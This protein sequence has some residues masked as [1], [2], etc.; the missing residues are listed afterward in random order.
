MEATNEGETG[1]NARGKPSKKTGDTAEH[2]K[3][4]DNSRQLRITISHGDLQ[5]AAYPVIAGH[6]ENDG[7]LNAE[8]AI[9]GNLDQALM[10]RHQLGIYPGAIGTGEIFLTGKKGFKGALIVGLG[11]PGDLTASELTKTVEQGIVVYLL[12]PGSCQAPGEKAGEDNVKGISSLMVGCGYGG[13]S[14]EDSIKAIIQGVSNGNY[15][16]SNVVPENPPRIGHLEFVEMYEDKAINALFS[17]SRIEAEE[18]NPLKIIRDNGGINR[19]P[20]RMKRIPVDLTE[21]WWSRISVSRAVEKGKSVEKMTFR[22]STT[23][24]REE[25]VEL[26]TSPALLEGKIDAVSTD[27]KWDPGKAKTLFE[28]LIP[29]DFKEKL[30]KLGNINWIVDTYSAGFPWELL[31][32]GLLDSKPLCV[33]TGMIR[34]LSTPD[35][36]RSIKTV[37]KNRALVVADPDLK[38]F[39]GQLK[40]ARE[41]GELVYGLLKDYLE[42]TKSIGEDDSE[43]TGKLF[44]DDYKIIHFAGHGIFNRD[45]SKGSGMV[46]GKN[47]LLSSREI[48]QMST[49]P[50]LVFLNCC[51]LGRTDGESELL[52]QKRYKLAANLGTQLIDNG[53]KCVIAAGWAVDDNAALEF[54]RVFYTRMFEGY[55]F[56]EAVKEARKKVYDTYKKSNTWG[57][58]Q[59]YGDPFYRFEHIRKNQTPTGKKYLVAQEAEI[60]LENLLNGLRTSN[61]PKSVSEET[62]K[63]ITEAAIHD[64]VN[65]QAIMEKQALIWQELGEFEKAGTIYR[66]LMSQ[67]D[68]TF[69]F[70]VIENAYI[71]GIQDA[72]Q[73]SR[74][75]KWA[76]STILDAI[77]PIAED[78][79]NLTKMIPSVARQ[80]LLGYVCLL[81][82]SLSEKKAGLCE[83]AAYSFLQGYLQNRNSYSLLLY[84]SLQAILKSLDSLTP[85]PG[86]GNKSA[87]E[88]DDPADDADALLAG[89]EAGLQEEAGREEHGQVISACFALCNYIIRF[90]EIPDTAIRNI[91]KEIRNYRNEENHPARHFLMD[92]LLEFFID[93]LTVAENETTTHLRNQ[94]ILIQKESLT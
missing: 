42:T 59:C 26:F 92:D 46:I 45:P 19:I 54:A 78:L 39:A 37:P 35:F 1:G 28:M 67:E 10:R 62:L 32:P 3:E 36:R 69:S 75:K 22:A 63:Q 70:A 24:A 81:K 66:Q 64:Q 12:H 20:G 4:K 80:N 33:S 93:A 8:K 68:M 31:Q 72:A 91:A 49:S 48:R 40:G 85:G 21:T 90:P 9:N 47:L 61:K 43:I 5:Y 6:F 41:E 79:E 55:T 60:D 87:K 52:W 84:L 2:L 18:N 7:I 15:K 71:T 29:N 27:C 65:N 14:I 16:V 50:E 76:P 82:A 53:V 13:L 73:K 25:V 89:I 94:L 58:Y 57:A 74:D 88:K 44:M 51:H 30:K 86:K 17:V 77:N 83:K 38:G 23:G 56:S 11:K 34:Q